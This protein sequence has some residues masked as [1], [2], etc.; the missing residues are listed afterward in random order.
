MSKAVRYSGQKLR[1][2]LDHAGIKGIV[3][4]NE[5]EAT[6]ITCMDC[7]RVWAYTHDEILALPEEAQ[8]RGELTRCWDCEPLEAC[9]E[10]D[11]CKAECDTDD[12]LP[13][14]C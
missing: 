12:D 11:A 5:G 6:Q 9:G 4:D 7:G 3:M 1:I 10:C 14:A 8:A 13:E 2:N